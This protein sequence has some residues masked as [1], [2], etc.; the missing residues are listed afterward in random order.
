MKTASSKPLFIGL[1]FG[2]LIS[3]VFTTPAFAEG[4]TPEGVPEA[5]PTAPLEVAAAQAAPGGEADDVVVAAVE[6]VPLAAQSGANIL[7]TTRGFFF[8]TCPGGK[9]EFYDLT[10]PSDGALAIW[11]GKSGSGLIYLMSSYTFTGDVTIDGST[12][13]YGTL[14]GLVM[15]TTSGAALPTIAGF[16]DVFNI[17]GGFTLKDV[18]I[19][20]NRDGASAVHFYNNTGLLTISNVSIRNGSSADQSN[21]LL[22]SHNGPVLLTMVDSSHNLGYGAMIDTCQGVGLC[23]TAGSVTITNSVFNA[24][25]NGP[26]TPRRWG[27][28][29]SARGPVTI[30][31]ISASGNNGD[32]LDFYDV[33]GPVTIRNSTFNNNVDNP[34]FAQYGYGIYTIETGQVPTSILIENVEANSNKDAGMMLKAVGSIT[35]RSSVANN[36]QTYEGIRICGEYDCAGITFGAASVTLSDLELLFNQMGGLMAD[37]SGAITAGR[38]RADSSINGNGIYLDN[39]R[40]SAPVNVSQVSVYNNN[41]YGLKIVSRRTVTLNNINATY[42]SKDNIAVN[43]L[44]VGSTGGVTMLNTLGNNQSYMS[45]TSSGVVISSWG[46]VTLTGLESDSNVV[47]GVVISNANGNMTLA[48][49]TL[50]SNRETGLVVESQGA[51]TWTGGK[52]YNNGWGGL[53]INGGGARLNNSAAATPK[54]VTVRDADTGGNQGPGLNDGLRILSDGAVTLTNIQSNSNLTGSGLYVDNSTGTAPVS[55]LCTSLKMS[56]GF[57]SNPLGEGLHIVSRGSITLVRVVANGN[58]LGNLLTNT[59][60]TGN[61]SISGTTSAPSGFSNNGIGADG[62]S[63]TTNGMVTLTNVEATGNN[64]RGMDISAGK[65]VTVNGYENVFSGNTNLQGLYIVTPASVTLSNIIAQFN[66]TASGV[67]VDNHLGAGNVTVLCPRADLVCSF[68]SNGSNGLYVLTSGTITVNHIYASGNTNSGASLNGAG[69][70]KGAVVSNSVFRY[71]TAGSVHGLRI[72]VNG[73]ITVTN[74]TAEMN[75]VYGAQLD[76]RNTSPTPTA[77]PVTVTR[78]RFYGNSTGLQVLSEG[79]VTLNGIT[80]NGNTGMGADINNSSVTFTNRLLVLSSAGRNFFSDNSGSIGLFM[81]TSGAVTLAG[82][83]AS[84][85]GME[86]IHLTGATTLLVSNTKTEFNA[87]SGLF[88]WISGSITLNGMLSFSNGVTFG[89]DG[90]TLASDTGKVTILNSTFTANSDSG[91]DANVVTPATQFTI[92]NSNYFGN[93]VTSSSDP[94]LYVH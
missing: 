49:I 10:N 76:N 7:F 29:I 35:I 5:P 94:N 68:S 74:I 42:N 48:K 47:N 83:T 71:N 51:I 62:M 84:H 20:R 77:W 59:A 58:G 43:T 34:D 2:L 61:V 46:P 41:G 90:V 13:G 30:N 32:G 38:I 50:T 54:P 27:L 70:G 15:D 33:F 9:C 78:S 81:Q 55:I 45:I 63:I 75:N 87:S 65:T 3:L 11:P 56:N 40:G 14:H 79:T 12:A 28:E 93:Q 44:L 86:G 23:T 18:I 17:T 37:V 31:G 53:V 72:Q 1:A 24:N 73:P 85:N 92:L 25:G 57:S 82:I 16:V 64:L 39:S 66:T 89:G 60:G 52:A 8:G 36:N 69:I 22:V 67:Y 19:Q 6:A 91:V 26:T 4:D 21:G 88:A 80:A